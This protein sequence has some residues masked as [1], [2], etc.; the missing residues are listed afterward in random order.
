MPGRYRYIEAFYGVSRPVIL[1]SLRR[2]YM[3]P[4]SSTWI[5]ALKMLETEISQHCTIHWVKDFWYSSKMWKED[6]YICCDRWS[7]I[8]YSLQACCRY[9]DEQQ[10]SRLDD[11]NP[12]IRI[13]NDD[14]IR[15]NYAKF[16]DYFI[17]LKI[18]SI[19]KSLRIWLAERLFAIRSSI[20]VVFLSYHCHDSHPLIRHT[21]RVWIWSYC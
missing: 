8:Y 7:A 16:F 1:H 11:S 10:M 14:I 17:Q 21:H 19:L 4:Y 6:W 12:N 9:F 18:Y 15:Y 3:A 5:V 20:V 13:N 2:S